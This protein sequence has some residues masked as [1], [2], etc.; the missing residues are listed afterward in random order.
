[1]K[2]IEKALKNNLNSPHFV[3]TEDVSCVWSR[4]LLKTLEEVRQHVAQKKS[5][6]KCEILD[7]NNLLGWTISLWFLCNSKFLVKTANN[8]PK[9]K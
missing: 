8:S 4:F 1:M 9:L 5:Y 3:E 7:E 6:Q 2:N